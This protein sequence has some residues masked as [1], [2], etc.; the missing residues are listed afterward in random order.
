MFLLKNP[1]FKELDYDFDD[2]FKNWFN[3]GF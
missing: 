3:P 1:E 2:I